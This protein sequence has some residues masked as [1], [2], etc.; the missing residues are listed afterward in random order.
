MNLGSSLCTVFK[1]PTFIQ[2]PNGYAS[3][4]L[5]I[6]ITQPHTHYHSVTI[7]SVNQARASDIRATLGYLRTINF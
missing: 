2:E 5:T 1:K 4:E 6:H 7:M 3:E